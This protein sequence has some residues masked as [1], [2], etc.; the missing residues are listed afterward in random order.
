MAHGPL[1]IIAALGWGMFLVVFIISLLIAGAIL[2]IGAKV[3]RV[4]NVTLGKSMLAVLAGSVLAAIILLILSIIPI[5]GR[6]LGPILAI[7]AYVWVIKAI[8]N[9]TWG[10]AFIA[11]LMAVIVQII[12]VVVIVMATAGIGALL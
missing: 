2:L 9:T 8:F 4:E 3:A 1:G 7:I 5:I 12:V 11:W 10:K 6:I